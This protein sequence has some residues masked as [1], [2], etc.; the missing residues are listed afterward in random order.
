M[1]AVVRLARIAFI[2]VLLAAMF[3]GV[4]A[5]ASRAVLTPKCIAV[6]ACA[7]FSL[8]WEQALPNRGFGSG[9]LT[10]SPAGIDCKVTSGQESGT[11]ENTFAWPIGQN[12][13]DLL[14]TIAPATGS[15]GCL[16]SCSPPDLA[17]V[18][19]SGNEIEVGG[20]TLT[21][22]GAIT[23][24]YSFWTIQETVAVTRSG[25]GTGTI[26]ST[27]PVSPGEIQPNGL[28]CGAFCTIQ[29]D[30]GVP[31]TLIATPD[32]G[33]VFTQWTG[34]CAGQSATCKLDPTTA[35]STNAVFGLASQT[36]TTTSKTTTTASTTTTTTTAATTTTAVG[37][38]LEAQL[39]A[40][41]SGKSLLGARVEKV[42]VQAGEKLTATLVL[43]RDGKRLAHTS[44]PGIRT[45]DR[46]LTLPIP[47]SV[48]KGKATITITLTDTSGHHHTWTR[49]INVPR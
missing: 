43:A 2:G 19:A 22:G 27:E 34:A 13:P 32:A 9:T 23:L 28:N 24:D 48:A 16:K 14:L 8:A 45:G 3:A 15:S 20:G 37:Y 40:V 38:G 35:L 42:E 12:A 29:F 17:Y 30:Y 46:V 1:R 49:T 6:Y 4:P 47:G 31:I 5:S 10:S 39:I 26:T 21:P 11:C 41:K 33:A 7:T 36:T 18:A 44:I 25:T